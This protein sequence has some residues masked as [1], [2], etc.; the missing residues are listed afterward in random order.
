[1]STS[2]SFTTTPVTPTTAMKLFTVK[3]P[4]VRNFPKT[5]P[6]SEKTTA[7]MIIRGCR[8]ERNWV[9]MIKYIMSKATEKA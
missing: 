3:R 5:T 9:A 2:A 4:W 1:M 6:I 7:D 8:Y